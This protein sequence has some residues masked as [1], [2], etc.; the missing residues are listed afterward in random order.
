MTCGF[1]DMVEE[2]S[3]NLFRLL[4]H[5]NKVITIFEDMAFVDICDKNNKPFLLNPI[6]TTPKNNLYSPFKINT[7][8]GVLT[9]RERNNISIYSCLNVMIVIGLG[10]NKN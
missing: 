6:R 10:Y 4:P 3:R 9:I 5:R 8:L 7:E 1:D 2:G